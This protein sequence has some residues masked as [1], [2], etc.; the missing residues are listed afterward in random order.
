MS[1]VK[2]HAAFTL[3][4]PLGRNDIVKLYWAADSRHLYLQSAGASTAYYRIDTNDS[5][6]SQKSFPDSL[7]A[8]FRAAKN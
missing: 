6:V 8:Y 3:V 4:G 2:S 5:S 7:S 1:R